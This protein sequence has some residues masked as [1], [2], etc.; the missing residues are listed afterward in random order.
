MRIEKGGKPTVLIATPFFREECISHSL[1]HGIPYLPFV[2]I[3]ADPGHANIPEATEKV[4]DNMVKALTTPAEELQKNVP[5]E[6]T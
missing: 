4:F 2:V 6:M 1:M 5:G 3:D